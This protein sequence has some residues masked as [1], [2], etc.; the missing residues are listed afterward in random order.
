MLRQL[1]PSDDAARRSPG[2]HHIALDHPAP[3]HLRLAANTAFDAVLPHSIQQRP[4]V[5]PQLG[6]LLDAQRA[7]VPANVSIAGI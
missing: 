3:T 6:E 5:M 4:P 1:D 7:R 2:P